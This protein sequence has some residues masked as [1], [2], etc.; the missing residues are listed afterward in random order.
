MA[1]GGRDPPLRERL[2]PLVACVE[3]SRAGPENV[4]AAGKK[5]GEPLIV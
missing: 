5:G 2:W 3:K 1:P 4:Q